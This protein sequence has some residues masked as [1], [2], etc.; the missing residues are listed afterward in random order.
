MNKLKVTIA[1][2][3]IACFGFGV[4]NAQDKTTKPATKKTT[5]KKATGGDKATAKPAKDTPESKPGKH[6]KKDGTPDKRYKE[7]KTGGDKAA[8]KPGADKT[9]TKKA[10]N[11]ATKPAKK[12]APKKAA[13]SNKGM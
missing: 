6:L 10:D 4:I 12:A 13:P 8:A 1:G 5:T 11:G 7:N 2:L 3:L 9:T